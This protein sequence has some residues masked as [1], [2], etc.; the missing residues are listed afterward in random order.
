M[1][2]YIPLTML[3]AFL[4]ALIENSACSVMFPICSISLV[5]SCRI[6]VVVCWFGLLV[7]LIERTHSDRLLDQCRE[8]FLKIF[9][10]GLSKPMHPYK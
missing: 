2:E 9:I 1:S 5:V 7:F 4:D 6:I 8:K 3:N 10:L